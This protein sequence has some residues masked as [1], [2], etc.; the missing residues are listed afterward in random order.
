M[1][2]AV[3]TMAYGRG[4]PWH[5]EGTK[6]ANALSTAEEMLAA[7]ELD[8][9]VLRSP[10]FTHFNGQEI[11]VPNRWAN[12]RQSDGAVLGDVGDAYQIVQ[13]REA[14]AF[15]DNL[16]DSGAAKYETAGSLFGGRRVFLSMELPEGISV[17]G[18]ESEIKPYLLITNGHDGGTILQASVTMV[19]VVCANT[20]TLAL[21]EAKR[22]FRIRHTGSIDGKIQAARE[23]LG[24]TFRY[25]EEFSQIAGRLA[26]AK[27]TDRQIDKILRAAF[28]VPASQ[29]K[30]DR[31]EQSDFWKVRDLYRNT[32]NIDSIRGTAWGLLQATGEYL[33]HEV[34]YH[35]RRFS[36][37]DVRMDS[38]VY[39]GP[40]AIRKQK[41]LSLIG[42]AVKVPVRVQTR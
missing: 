30:P 24:I 2:A 9:T 29:T 16:V 23:A 37:V 27:V 8:W 35:G 36:D 4:I 20:W 5:R 32:E 17:P 42:S 38:I 26:M 7:A 1:T 15:A 31:I 41:V 6:T 21:G 34:D 33:D 12:V 14:F 18:D 13:N 22:T 3:E 39:D 40:A 11:Q 10:M 25:T 28:P 19:R